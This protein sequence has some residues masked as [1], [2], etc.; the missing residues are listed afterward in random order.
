MKKTIGQLVEAQE[1]IK[2]LMGQVLPLSVSYSVSE[3]FRLIEPKAKFFEEKRTELFRMYGTPDAKDPN[4]LVIPP[5]KM[6]EFGA[7]LNELF[8]LEVSLDLLEIDVEE[9][10]KMEE[11]DQKINIAPVHLLII[12][13]LFEKPIEEEIK[14]ELEKEIKD[15]QI[16]E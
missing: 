4:N 1:A 8:S 7:K 2:A 15:E 6:Q 11:K 9:I 13:K 10:L 3:C 14:E 16:G 12:K 5:E